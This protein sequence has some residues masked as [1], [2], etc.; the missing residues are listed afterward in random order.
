MRDVGE[1]GRYPEVKEALPATCATKS[2]TAILLTPTLVTGT[3]GALTTASIVG[4]AVASISFTLDAVKTNGIGPAQ[5]LVLLAVRKFP[6]CK[7]SMTDP[8]P[9]ASS[10]SYMLGCI[11][12]LPLIM[13]QLEL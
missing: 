13:S 11:S 2:R 5:G 3:V 9:S 7:I 12:K 8:A 1:M 10:R 6:Y 4:T